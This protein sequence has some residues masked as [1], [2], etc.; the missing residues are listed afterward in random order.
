MTLRYPFIMHP[1]MG[2]P[3]RAEIKLPTDSPETP[4]VTLTLLAVAG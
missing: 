2:G 1:G 4:N 3:H